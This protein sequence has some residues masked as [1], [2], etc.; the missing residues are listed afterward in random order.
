[1]G[2]GSRKAQ[3]TSKGRAK[4]RSDKPKL[5]EDTD[6]EERVL[7]QQLRQ[8]GLYAANILGDGNCLFRALSDQM[9]GSPNHHLQLREQICGELD[10]RGD[11][12]RLF[13]DEDDY[14]GGWQGYV[15]EMKQPGTYGTN[16]ELSAFVHL[17]QRSIKI[18][19]PGL[20]YVMQ[21]EPSCDTPA[22]SKGASS[23]TRARS[24]T[25]TTSSAPLSAR[26]K[27]A[28]ARQDKM[29]AKE[30][31]A[32]RKGKGKAAERVQPS[33]P[34]PEDSGPLCIVYH[35]WE[36]YSSLRNL[37]GP[38][39][40]PPR[41]RIA[42]TDSPGMVEHPSDSH[43][44]RLSDEP[45]SED[46][47][48]EMSSPPPAEASSPRSEPEPVSASQRRSTRSIM[49][50]SR[51]LDA[52]VT[53][54]RCTPSPPPSP[55]T[56]AKPA[57][58]TNKRDRSLLRSQEEEAE[59][60]R[61]GTLNS[62]DYRGQSPALTQSSATS[63]SSSDATAASQCSSTTTHLDLEPVDEMIC[64]ERALKADEGDLAE[65]EH[66]NVFAHSDITAAPSS[67]RKKFRSVDSRS[68][69][70]APPTP[71]RSSSPPSASLSS[72]VALTRSTRG[73]T[74]RE[75][76]ELNRVRRMERRRNSPQILSAAT[77]LEK[78]DKRRTSARTAK[79]AQASP[80]ARTLRN[81]KKFGADESA[82]TAGLRGDLK[83]LY[84]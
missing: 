20:V 52:S 64:Q 62:P 43:V 49:S 31:G 39:T 25:A 61:N 10:E 17:F 12:Y 54:N 76:K 46:A 55:P 5:I 19:Q 33:A 73:P 21:P 24:S 14:Q 7:S 84:I 82:A 37:R 74:A 1:M 68:S 4:T 66:R 72:P 38:H 63:T 71:A 57:T 26:E 29:E 30:A 80:P 69:S 60:D 9:F 32:G 16:I 58:S 79:A 81:G 51:T 50:N 53:S 40:G 59:R 75:K 6:Q 83:E 34:H 70:P 8:A 13:V 45:G 42:R 18:F 44:D 28:K 36:H 77:A 27:R 23:P 56:R 15:R 22:S 11:R 67:N 2:G 41:L 65:A 35:S 48:A 78:T 3:V 47:D